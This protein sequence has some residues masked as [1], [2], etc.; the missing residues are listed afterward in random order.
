MGPPA[1][2]GKPPACGVQFRESWTGQRLPYVARG[3]SGAGNDTNALLAR[4]ADW[5]TDLSYRLR[6]RSSALPV[7]RTWVNHR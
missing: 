4:S 3:M 1:L 5:W 6:L 7:R 2:K